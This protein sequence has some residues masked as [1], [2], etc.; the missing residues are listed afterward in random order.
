MNGS[1][2]RCELNA[3]RSDTFDQRRRLP[4]MLQHHGLVRAQ[5]RFGDG[6]LGRMPMMPHTYSYSKAAAS[7]ARKNAPTL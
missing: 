6:A 1:F 2:N 5:R 4:D 7:A 3:A